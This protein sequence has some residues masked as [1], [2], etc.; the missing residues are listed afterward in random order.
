MGGIAST[1]E[2]SGNFS[3]ADI[4]QLVTSGEII[5]YNYDISDD[6]EANNVRGRLVKMEYKDSHSASWGFTSY[7][8]DKYGR[9]ELV[10]QSVLGLGVTKKIEYVYR[11]S[12]K[13]MEKRYQPGENDGFYEWYEYDHLGRI[14]AQ[15]ASPDSIKPA[16]P[17]KEYT[18]NE[19]G[20]MISSGLY[21]YQFHARYGNKSY[22]K[23][24]KMMI[25]K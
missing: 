14:V 15:Y 3:T 6:P 19:I 8:Y 10:K 9:I 2:T 13:L 23:T 16:D 25:L 4:E 12:G 17:V 11:R 22:M 5:K 7:S 1:G 24:K 18:Y 20:Q 21:F